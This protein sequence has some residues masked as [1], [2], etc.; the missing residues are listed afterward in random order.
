VFYILI[1]GLG[2]AMVVSLLE[3]LYKS[4]KEAKKKKVTVLQS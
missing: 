2:M 4:K 1:G 3:F